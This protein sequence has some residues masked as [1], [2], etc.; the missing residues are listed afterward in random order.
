ML[1]GCTGEEVGLGDAVAVGHEYLDRG[2]LEGLQ[3]AAQALDASLVL[4]VADG[5][6]AVHGHH[7]MSADALG[8]RRHVEVV[9]EKDLGEQALWI[10]VGRADVSDEGLGLGVFVADVHSLFLSL[11]SILI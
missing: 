5:G 9:R 7:A 3:D 4:L 1:S 8:E 2:A 11:T 6:R 10:C